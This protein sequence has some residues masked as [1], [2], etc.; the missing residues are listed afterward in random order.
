MGRGASS[1]PILLRSPASRNTLAREGAHE[2]KGQEDEQD[3]KREED[4]DLALSHLQPTT[5][6]MGAKEVKDLSQEYRR[7]NRK[8]SEKKTCVEHS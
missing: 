7:A 6:H 1:P 3:C 4:P 8:N 2:E 5:G